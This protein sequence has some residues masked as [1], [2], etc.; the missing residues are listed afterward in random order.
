MNITKAKIAY[1]SALWIV[2]SLSFTGYVQ[3]QS[4]ND[5]DLLTEADTTSRTVE[6]DKI[7]ITGN[8][9]TKNHI[10]MRELD[11]KP[12]ERYNIQDLRVILDDDR[13]KIYNTSLFNSV[14]IHIYELTFNKVLIQVDVDERWY[15]YPIPKIAFVDRN[16][17]DW[18]V[19]RGADLSRLNYGIK[20]T[21]YNFRGRKERL[22]LLLQGGYTKAA[23][24]QYDIPYID[25]SQRTGLSYNIS[26]G[27]NTNMNYSTIDNVQQYLDSD[28]IIK[29]SFKTQM[30]VIRRNSFYI[31]HHFGLEYDNQWIADTVV[32]LN[33]EYFNNSTTRQQFFTLGYLFSSD[34]RDII[35]YPLRG[36][37]FRFSVIKRGL[38]I[39]DDLN[40][41]N[42]LSS[43]A[44]FWEFN[45]KLFLSN[46]TSVYLSFPARQP[47]ANISGLG[48]SKNTIRGYE[49][50]VI[51]GKSY[52]INKTTFK[53]E[54]FSI[55]KKINAIPVKQFQTFPL[56]IY[57][58]TYFDFGYVNNLENPE[59]TTSLT[60]TFIYG[61]GLGLDIFTT[62]DL[63]IRME[64]SINSQNDPGFFLHF[65]KEF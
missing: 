3:S 21:Q 60:N 15:F 30:S 10:I 42:I 4:A 35:A 54:L 64:Y 25:K 6:I 29:T 26:Y 19:N 13:N 46:Y 52:M 33:S 1:F 59:L 18:V 27:E 7:I 57:L 53:K 37:L 51:D 65:R 20:F 17:N 45:N 61:Y 31:R 63:V 9:K 34:H 41:F 36:Y 48:Y 55:N 28:L 24:L 16:F 8:K 47:Y 23:G 39:F 62:Y 22:H 49:L 44:K 40:M 14:E 5:T 12:G 56:A 50:L 32:N 2:I 58:K 11:I 43:Y 38:G